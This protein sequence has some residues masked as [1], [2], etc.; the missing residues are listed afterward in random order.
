MLVLVFQNT[1]NIFLNELTNLITNEA[2]PPG[3]AVSCAMPCTYESQFRRFVTCISSD[4]LLRDAVFQPSTLHFKQ[5]NHKDNLC[6][7]QKAPH[8]SYQFSNY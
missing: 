7:L 2:G 8:S 1:H 3:R 6:L 5:L 4:I